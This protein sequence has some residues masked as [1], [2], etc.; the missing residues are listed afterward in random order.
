MTGTGAPEI[1][2]SHGA[3]REDWCYR[4]IALGGHLQVFVHFQV[5]TN[6]RA[7]FMGSPPPDGRELCCQINPAPLYIIHNK[8]MEYK[9][10]AFCT[11]PICELCI[12]TYKAL[13]FYHHKSCR[14]TCPHDRKHH[15]FFAPDF[16]A[17][18]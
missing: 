18:P 8:K 3:R 13:D 1:L 16:A 4:E 12:E 6:I 15:T 5:H 7:I 2:V 11:Q 14:D 10:C 17:S 9:L